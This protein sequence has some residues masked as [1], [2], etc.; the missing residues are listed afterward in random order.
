MNS[1][2]HK[3]WSIACSNKENNY[4]SNFT[5]TTYEHVHNAREIHSTDI[6][7]RKP[8][9]SNFNNTDMYLKSGMSNPLISQSNQSQDA[10]NQTRNLPRVS[11][12][13]LAWTYFDSPQLRIR[14]G[15]VIIWK[16]AADKHKPHSTMN[17]S[18]CTS[19]QQIHKHAQIH[20]HVQGQRKH[21][22]VPIQSWF[23]PSN[24]KPCRLT[25]F[26]SA[27]GLNHRH[28]HSNGAPE[29]TSS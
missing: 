9:K 26:C 27:G 21:D 25:P 8:I 23:I 2:H 14:S 5:I 10:Q 11:I 17:Q 20:K 22:T 16:T 12:R 3:S 13:R 7:M 19:S 29:W 28:S 15:L 1:G 24:I 18:Q 6:K 4:L